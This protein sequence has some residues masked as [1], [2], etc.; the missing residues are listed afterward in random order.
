M[1]FLREEWDFNANNLA[2]FLL[3]HPYLHP[4]SQLPQLNTAD[5]W[6]QIRGS[7][8]IIELTQTT[9]T[10]Q[11]MKANDQINFAEQLL[12]ATQ[13]VEM[14]Q[15]LTTLLGYIYLLEPNGTTIRHPLYAYDD[16][17]VGRSRQ[18][19]LFLQSDK[20][21]ARHLRLT[22][23]AGNLFVTD[24]NS[25][26]GTYINNQSLSAQHPYLLHPQQKIELGGTGKTACQLW[27]V[28][29]SSEKSQFPTRQTR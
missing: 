5:Q 15:V 19:Q 11:K 4:K 28:P 17:T 16:L 26:N 3:F 7:P 21:S 9:Q 24:L 29:L 27:F 20:I 8:D 25:K 10:S 1:T 18:Q 22:S 2:T 13:W 23:D 12:G 14:R 6:L